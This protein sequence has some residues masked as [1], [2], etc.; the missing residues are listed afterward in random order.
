MTSVFAWH[1]NGIDGRANVLLRD[2][3]GEVKASIVVI[4][5]DRGA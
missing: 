2:F 5:D 1:P 3:H 4:V